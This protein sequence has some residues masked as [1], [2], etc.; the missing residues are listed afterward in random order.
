VLGIFPRMAV[1]VD[2]HGVAPEVDCRA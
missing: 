2:D 1:D